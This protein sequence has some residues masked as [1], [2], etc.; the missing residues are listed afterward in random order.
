M[1][2]RLTLDQAKQFKEAVDFRDPVAGL[3]HTYY[4]YPARFSPEFARGAIRAFTAPG[5]LVLDPFMGG[6]TTLVE[7][8]ASGRTVIGSDISSLSA[9]VSHV[10]TTPLSQTDLRDIV[11]WAKRLPGHLNLHK[12][13]R[14]PKRW[15]REGYQ[16]DLPW[17]LRKTMEQ[18]LLRLRYLRTKK[19]QRFA[20]CLILRVGQW[21]MDCKKHIP[22]V[23]EFR[24]QVFV[25]LDQFV[26]GMNSLRSSILDNRLPDG[27]KP[28]ATCIQCKARDIAGH[29]P[30]RQ[31]P[32]LVLTSP[33]YPGVYVLYHRWKVRGRRET[34]A[35]FWV[36]NCRDGHGQA[37][38]C[39]GHRKQAELKGYF[40]GIRESFEG[41]G[42]AIGSDA[43]VVQLVAFAEP[44]WQ[45]KAY[46]DAMRD[47]GFAEVLPR[48]L[49]LRVRGRMRRNVPGRRWFAHLQDE[50]ATSQE[51]VLFHRKV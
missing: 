27:S 42:K 22:P 11:D 48:D 26:M 17:P 36:T 30:P 41:V 12:R 1:L 21:A 13:H 39:F 47:A 33:P 23:K 50:L 14:R 10:K 7:A 32:K 28:S 51:L 2:D 40:T 18:M 5:D 43:I 9:F 29:V 35:P 24:E 45:T 37:H 49:G 8:L 25:D 44:D 4:L 3:T 46:L 20:R 34:P 15:S 31:K 6:G 38:Y 16:K 19:Q